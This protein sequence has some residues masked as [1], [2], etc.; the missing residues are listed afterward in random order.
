MSPRSVRLRQVLSGTLVSCALIAQCAGEEFLPTVVERATTRVDQR[1]QRPEGLR[2]DDRPAL[3]EEGLDLGLI[4]SAAY[5]DNI[6]L[7]QVNEEGDFV[8][9][10]TPRLAYG[11]GDPASKQG[12]YLRVAYRPTAVV[13]LDHRDDSRIDHDL[14]WDAGYNGDESAVRYSGS[15]RRLGDATADIGNQT[16]RNEQAH[17][18]RLAWMPRERISVELGAALEKTDYDTALLAD[19]SK[20]LGEA[21]L[22]CIYS[23]KTQ[24][25]LA[26]RGG[27]EEVDGAPDQ[28]VHRATA[29]LVWSP[30]RKINFDLEVGAE[31]R[32]FA[33][34][35]ETYPVFEARADW[36]PREGTTLYLA[37]YRR[38]EASAFFNGQNYRVT[39]VTGGVAQYLGSGWTARLE[40]GVEK[41]NYRRVSGTGPANRRDEI[42]FIRPALAYEVNE[43]FSVNVFYQYSRN[44][45]NNPFFGYSNH[46]AGVGMD[47][48]F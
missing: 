35:S 15:F 23:P 28:D 25:V 45:S 24:I 38:E 43:D 4:V 9:R 40:G 10:V 31:H 46:Q 17:L 30:R 32:E 3:A 7:S 6:F 19:S 13:Y 36:R 22:R 18:V 33:N 12:G 1:L 47:Y 20:L 44:D 21:A 29:R 26:Y 37:G 42:Y 8:I 14:Q 5:D 2:R 16:E 11:I 41:A 27:R 34:G 39:G 48:S